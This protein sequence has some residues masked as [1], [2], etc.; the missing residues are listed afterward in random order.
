MKT[1]AEK[2]LGKVALALTAVALVQLVWS[3]IRLLTISEPEPIAPAAESL[4]VDDIRQSP[5]LG[6]EPSQ[7]LGARPLFWEGRQ[8][9]VPSA[10]T[11]Q[12]S[13]AQKVPA[14]TNIDQVALRGVYSSGGESGVI[15]DYKGE[16]QRLRKN[17]SIAGWTFTTLG[18]DGPVFESGEE[19]RVLELKHARSAPA[20]AKPQ[21]ATP[22]TQDKASQSSRDRSKQD[23]NRQD[24]KRQDKAKK[25]KPKNRTG[26]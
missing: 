17:E 24:R 12:V 4:Q 9:F 20:P 1:S 22:P 18:D 26:E 16:R 13:E 21:A 15:V 23:R 3:G 8:A 10:D 25:D 14:N 5:A 6:E 11:P 7:Y 19:L 2:Q